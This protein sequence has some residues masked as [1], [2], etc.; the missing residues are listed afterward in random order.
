MSHF[1][2]LPLSI[3]LSNS[4]TITFS[5]YELQQLGPNA[6]LES[7]RGNINLSFGYEIIDSSAIWSVDPYFKQSIP[8]R[9]PIALLGN[10]CSLY[11]F[12]SAMRINLLDITELATDQ[13][14]CD[15]ENLAATLEEMKRGYTCLNLDNKYAL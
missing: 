1:R 2:D 12:L 11:V 7:V 15:Q 13:I 9:F 8:L 14:F 6:S 3:V 10:I 5:C 4:Q